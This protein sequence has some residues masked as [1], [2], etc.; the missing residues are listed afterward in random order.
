[1]IRLL[2]LFYLSCAVA[3]SIGGTDQGRYYLEG[4]SISA[5]NIISH[6]L[7]LYG[8]NPYWINSILG[9]EWYL[10]AILLI[11]VFVPLVLNRI[12]TLKR[13][14]ILWMISIPLTVVL[15]V[16]L[17]VLNPV[18]NSIIWF[19]YIGGLSI[20]GH[21]PAIFSGIVLFRFAQSNPARL[22]NE[23]QIGQSVL[24]GSLTLLILLMFGDIKYSILYWEV[25]CGFAVLSQLLW[26]N[27]M[28][29]NPIF[30]AL[31]QRSYE[32]YL[33]HILLIQLFKNLPQIMNNVLID[34]LLKL[35]LLVGSSWL[36]GYV[37]H[38]LEL[39]VLNKITKRSIK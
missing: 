21:L 24:L 37:Y 38:Q 27:K 35:I 39:S 10:F 30:T 33:V 36:M 18:G 4:N 20:I 15:N 14:I 5:G 17:K 28:I 9:V 13:A 3:V 11:Y 2:P 25:L 34:W 7:M 23:K 32:I 12:E 8:F 26:S 19:N 22:E 6:I 31:G 29:K 1:M 16:L